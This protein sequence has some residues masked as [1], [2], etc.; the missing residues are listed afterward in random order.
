MSFY[1]TG[2]EDQRLQ[3]WYIEGVRGPKNIIILFDISYAMK[4]ENKFKFARTAVIQVLKG[5]LSNDFTNVSL[6]HVM[7]VILMCQ[8]NNSACAM[9]VFHKWPQLLK[10]HDA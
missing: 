3:P 1:I 8:C 10:L 2:A 5:M 6:L 4:E 9:L 7:F